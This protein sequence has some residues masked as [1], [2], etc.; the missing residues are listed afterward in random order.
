MGQL[1]PVLGRRA[2]RLGF[3]LVGR[4]AELARIDAAL[5]AA[6]AG[7]SAVVVLTGEAG[8]G[9]SALLDAAAERA[10]GFRILRAEGCEH[11]AEL[12]F[13]AL[14]Q[15]LHGRL[16]DVSELP[17]RQARALR[18]ALAL[19]DEPVDRFAAFAA[20]L[21]VVE[22]LSDAAPLLVMVDDAQWVDAVSRDALAFAGR[23]LNTERVALL[24]AF[25]SDVPSGF[26]GAER[27][28][29]GP[30]VGDA[31]SRLVELAAGRPL[32]RTL[33]RR[34]ARGAAGNPLAIVETAAHA[35][36]DRVAGR[37]GV[38]EPPPPGRVAA[39][40]LGARL[41]RL[42]PAARRALLVA[43]AAGAE[44]PAIVL[45]AGQ[46]V[47]VSQQAFA[48]AEAAGLIA[49]DY[50]AVRFRHPVLASLAYRR[51]SSAE[52]RRAHQALAAELA[53]A[54]GSAA[55]RRAW[56]LAA[57]TLVPDEQIAAALA[58]AA[59]RFGR[60]SGHLAAAYAYE[61]AARLTPQPA[62]SATRLAAAADAARR[63]GRPTHAQGLLRAAD[64]LAETPA[65]RTRIAFQQA[66]LET[67][68]GSV[69]RAV[70]RF[71]A[72]AADADPDLAASA[73]AHAASAAVAAGDIACALDHARAAAALLDAPAVPDITRETVRQ[74]LGTVLVL[75][76]ETQA[77]AAL[78][79]SAAERL[80]REDDLPGSDYV[81][82]SLLWV[83]D[84]GLARRCLQR[85]LAQAR[86]D[87]DLRALPSALEILAQLEYRT[88]DWAAAHAL[89]AESVRIAED[90]EQR[91]QLA[92]SLAVLALI[93]A[94]RGDPGA[95]RHA[96]RAEALADRHRLPVIAEYTGAGRGLAALAE[97]RPEAGLEILLAVAGRVRR[98]G[99]GQPGVLQW[100]A[101]LLESAVRAGDADIARRELERL[102]DQAGTTNNAWSAAVVQRI[103]GLLARDYQSRFEAA[104]LCA[105]GAPFERARTRL[106]WGQRLRRDGR[107]I[108][109]REQ[110][111]EALAAFEQ[112]GAAPW[113][114][115]AHREL[116]ASGARPR[117]RTAPAGISL[118]NQEAQIAALVAGG[119][120]NREVAAQLYL[121]VKT[122]EA[123]LTRVYRKLGV[124]SRVQLAQRL[125]SR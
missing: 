116:Q 86:R 10:D 14:H 6:A 102:R 37:V 59:A 26:R 1:S 79:R 67:W 2:S 75:K 89:A 35:A 22:R 72:I 124:G 33:A 82:Q 119:A 74:I 50:R 38:G 34:F 96:D 24:L 68:T 71:A 17:G 80:A 109:A 78:L 36:D 95:A 65:Q 48:Q 8:I 125:S 70:E 45:A 122:V 25:R 99:R 57:A 114:R 87:G 15:L 63:A 56:H 123:T 5:A 60:R 21:G 4:E 52:R 110:L 29:V 44:Q 43:A 32:G 51:A 19:S 118:T 92:F 107:R 111:R 64:A 42:R 54:S 28:A 31:A 61:R 30:L 108:A 69:E 83:E 104:L 7:R 40:A 49:V 47:G 12:P 16:G 53:G 106:C 55:E 91:V 73:R 46:R 115:T 100:E 101:D 117:R 113:A 77:G 39:E 20:V 120:S 76:G 66:L 81:A 93:E 3:V 62:Q 98:S 41:Q 105:A 84:Y 94:A 23:R 90:T 27:L 11:E 88:G 112:L 97:G 9:K 58:D 85:L 18:A 13:S 103:D 121:S